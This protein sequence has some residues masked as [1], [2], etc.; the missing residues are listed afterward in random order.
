MGRAVDRAYEAGAIVVAAGGQMIDSVTY[1]GK[2]ARTIGVGGVTWQRR[3]WFDYD[4]GQEMIDV[5]APAE[6]VLR[7]DSM[8][9]VGQAVM[10]P[11]EGDDPGAFALGSDS[12][13]GAYGTGDG[14]SYATTHV[15]AAAAM[16]LL[17]RQ[18]DI[19]RTYGEAWQRVEA[20]RRLLRTTAG[21]I[22]GKQPANRT[23]VLDIERLLLAALPAASSLRK[24]PLDKDKWA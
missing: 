8:A 17:L 22:N 9:A 6:G 24:A 12:H 23:G 15:A 18:D 11:I 2:Y 16:W 14:T 21:S 1:P 13:S 10:P 7:A 4:A 20:F 3:I 5:W 19:A